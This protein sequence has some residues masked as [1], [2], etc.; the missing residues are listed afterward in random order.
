MPF[1]LGLLIAAFLLGLLLPYPADSATDEARSAFLTAERA[2]RAGDMR[3]YRR[4]LARLDDYPLRPYLDFQALTRDL[5]AVRASEVD[6]FLAAWPDTVLADRLRSRWL[7]HLAKQRRWS[8]YLEYYRP[9]SSVTRQC[10]RLNAL[11]KTGQW[12]QALP[13]V[14]PIWLHGDSQPKACDPVFAVWTKAGMRTDELVWQRIE[15]T[16]K[17]G[18]RR[19]ARYLGRM[20][21]DMDRA[22]V[23]RWIKLHRRPADAANPDP[24]REAH[25]YREVMLSQAVR[26]LAIRDGLEGLSLWQQIK[27]RYPFDDAQRQDTEQYLVR[28]LVRVNDAASY[29]F[30][31]RVALQP[32]AQVAH[33]ARIRTALGRMDWPRVIEWIGELPQDQR[34]SARWQYWLGRALAETGD[35][36]SASE[37]YRRAASERTYYGFLAADRVDAPY[38]LDHAETPVDP[39]AIVE[40]TAMPSVERATELFTLQ[41]WLDGRREWHRATR[42][43]PKQKLKAAAKLAE[44]R[45]WHDR[46]I[47]TLAKTDY[48]DDLEL[49]FPVEHSALVLKH[50]GR[51]DI[52]SAWVYAVMRQESAFMPNA[53]S[54]A[55]AMGLMQ[56]MPATARYVARKLLATKPPSSSELYRPET[57]IALGSA[58]L[59]QMASQLGGSTVLATA[60]YNAGPHRVVRWLPDETLPADIWVEL[61][62]FRETRRYL[63]RVLAY[64]VIYEK[65]T[66]SEATRLSQRMPPVPPSINAVGRA[67]IDSKASSG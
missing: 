17:A 35:A 26:R 38:A 1:S 22:W 3:A 43:M 15:L 56:V 67:D 10:H 51:Q 42:D 20:L 11:I 19:L 18:N 37:H 25:P 48:W 52:D 46:A 30:V 28:N 32:D 50:S 59:K 16:M 24:F 21:P 6:D 39:D 23:E 40:V 7:D 5:V 54:H 60:A 44:S 65:R 57:N 61:V 55:G 4:E 45:G 53:R 62:P 49:R 8:A 31:R 36:T 33:E 27:D 9:T 63:Q 64:I 41:R 34:N 13:E 58:Y 47:F 14:P 12:Q 66:G 29:A 2:L